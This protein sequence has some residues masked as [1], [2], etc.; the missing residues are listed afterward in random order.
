MNI[1]ADEKDLLEPAAQ[2]RVWAP[3]RDLKTA[4]FRVHTL[5]IE[6]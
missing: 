4:R 1:D 5:N 2:V 6:P 3:Q